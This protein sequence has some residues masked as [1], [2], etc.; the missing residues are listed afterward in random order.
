MRLTSFTDFGLRALMRIASEPERP[1]S[2]AEIAG[3]FGISRHHLTKALA[4]LA[5]AGILATRRG[6]GGGAMLA[7]PA[8]EVRIGD[9][10]RVLEQGR[11]LVECFQPD[12]GACAIASHCR[13]KGMLDRAESAFLAELDG[14]TLAD[15]MLPKRSGEA[16][17][18]AP[19]RPPLAS[20][21]TRYQAQ[22]GDT[23]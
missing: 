10:V 23:R 9:V 14:Y 15:C 1:F 17:R 11:A 21:G 6:A 5:N 2:T 4:V 20:A 12:G 22:G 7:R 19:T 16:R 18:T 3:E 8:D 13:L